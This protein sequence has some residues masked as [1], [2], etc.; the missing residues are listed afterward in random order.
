MALFQFDRHPYEGRGWDRRTEQGATMGGHREKVVVCQ[1]RGQAF[2]HSDP[3]STLIS[4]L[5]LPD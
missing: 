5:Q 2:A 3:T 4:D 1:L